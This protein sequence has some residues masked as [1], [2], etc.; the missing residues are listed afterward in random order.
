MLYTITECMI[1]KT[2]FIC[3]NSYY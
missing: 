3:K 1:Y 2:V